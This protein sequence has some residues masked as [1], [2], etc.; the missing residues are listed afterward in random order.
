VTDRSA[1]GFRE[2]EEALRSQAERID[3]LTRTCASLVD[4]NRAFRLRQE[5]EK[6]RVVE[7]EK[8]RLAQVLLETHDGLELAFRAS[9]R[10]RGPGDPA[11]VGLRE[12]V[13]L[14][15]STLERRISEI[16]ASRL[17]VLGL[18]YDPRTGDRPGRGRRR[19]PGRDRD[20]GASP[21]MANRGP[22]APGGPGPGRAARQGLNFRRPRGIGPVPIG[23]SACFPPT[24]E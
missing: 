19:V 15:L 9:G 8:A 4:D 7:A 5:R 18:P 1:A 2:L 20:R 11:Q 10:D 21:G 16:G 22:R 13:R 6:D 17:E 3:D 23:F 24:N 14:T 12:G